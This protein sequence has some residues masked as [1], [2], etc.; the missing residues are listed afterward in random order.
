MT[1]SEGHFTQ[2]SRLRALTEAMQKVR[3]IKKEREEGNIFVTE[4]Q[5]GKKTG[6]RWR[7]KVRYHIPT[8]E[9]ACSE[10]PGEI[11][12]ADHMETIGDG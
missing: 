7:K 3:D 8:V 9:V 5:R 10:Y 11:P 6:G 1:H 12:E 2:G 4:T